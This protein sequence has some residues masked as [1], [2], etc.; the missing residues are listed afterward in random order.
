MH[1]YA[2]RILKLNVINLQLQTIGYNPHHAS[3]ELPTLPFGMHYYL[4]LFVIKGVFKGFAKYNEVAIKLG[5]PPLNLTEKEFMKEASN[6]LKGIG[7]HFI[8]QSPLFRCL[9]IY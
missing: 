1:F 7:S 2:E 3:L 9:E 6:S 8:C 4:I 5:Q